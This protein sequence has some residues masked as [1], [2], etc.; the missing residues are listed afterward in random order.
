[1]SAYITRCLL[2][3]RGLTTEEGQRLMDLDDEEDALRCWL[4]N[5]R[6]ARRELLSK[7][8]PIAAPGLQAVFFR[9]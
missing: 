7:E 1:M 2:A 8:E 3:E 9:G 6:A 4:A 5:V